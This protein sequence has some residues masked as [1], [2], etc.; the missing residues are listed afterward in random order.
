M[1]DEICVRVVQMRYEATGVV[2]LELAPLDEAPLP[3]FDPGAHIELVLS[4]GLRRSYS[5]YRPYD[6]GTCYS[7]AVQKDAASCGG[8]LH[9]HE[10]LRVGDTVSITPPRNNFPLHA[11]TVDPVFIAGGIGITPIL[12]MAS[13][14]SATGKGWTLYYA[15]RTRAAAAFLDDIAA[16]SDKGRVHPHFDEEQGGTHL[17]LT[18]IVKASP[19]ADFYCCGPKPMLEAFERATAPL[20]RER[21]HV[22]YFTAREEAAR[23]GG[24]QVVLNRSGRVLDVPAGR[25]ILDILLENGVAVSFSCS[26][27]VCGTCETRVIAGTPDH[28]DAVLSDEEKASG[29]TMMVCCSGSRSERLVLD[30]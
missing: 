27:G 1:A 12:C 16:L 20:P 18:A 14:L 17:D 7:V 24:F 21:V 23:T 25:T 5:L 3:R 11:S 10:T 6:G 15:A 22:E 19:D 9:I 2:S 30:L 13:D 29:R 4:S 8:S 26:E 28:R